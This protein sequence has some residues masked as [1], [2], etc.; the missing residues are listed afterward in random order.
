MWSQSPGSLPRNDRWQGRALTAVLTLT[1][2]CSP[3]LAA[4]R[5]PSWLTEL[6]SSRIP[7]YDNDVPAVVL[8]YERKITV[9]P[10]GKVTTEVRKA[11]RIL[12]RAGRKEAFAAVSYHNDTGKVRSLRA[13]TI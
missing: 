6:A 5:A 8:F 9:S 2:L 3:C 12:T 11:I 13:W 10:D 7:D 4:E 1:L